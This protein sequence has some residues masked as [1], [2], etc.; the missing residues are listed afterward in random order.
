[1]EGNIVTDLGSFK[2]DIDN[3][4]RVINT[5]I[6]DDSIEVSY[7]IPSNMMYLTYP[8]SQK[9]DTIRKDIYTVSDGKLTLSKSV[10]GRMIPERIIKEHIEW[11]EE[12]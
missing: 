4:E 7:R 8:P 3:G 12:D 1:M 10:Y 2:V 9:P 11:N 6:K 5:V